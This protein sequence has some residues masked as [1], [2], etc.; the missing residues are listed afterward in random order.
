M[1]HTYVLTLALA[2]PLGTAE[3]NAPLNLPLLTTAPALAQQVPEGVQVV[4]GDRW[5]FAIPQD[6]QATQYASPNIG[7]VS[8]VAQYES[9]DGAI[10]VNMVTEPYPGDATSYLELNLQ[11]MQTF[12]FVIHS[13]KPIMMGS[14]AGAE[15]ESSLPEIGIRVLQR[16]AIANQTGYVLTCRTLEDAFSEYRSQCSQILNTLQVNP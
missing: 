8:L 3:A 16:F 6:W 12:G 9:P 10:F 4:R 11:N 5:S 14:L 15:V 13:Q 2:F 7:N 1:K